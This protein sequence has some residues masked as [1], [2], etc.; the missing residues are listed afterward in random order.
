MS[1]VPLLD[2]RAQYAAIR[3]KCREAIDRVV[4]SQGLILGP[5]VE[6]F[7]REIAA[8]CGCEHAIG[9]SSG[10]DALLMAL[11]ALDVGRDDEV[12]IPAYT[13]FATA[14]SIAR[15][16]AKPVFVDVD[17][18]SLNIAVAK[19]EERIT[20]KTR[21][22]I[23]VH[24]YGQ[25]VDMDVLLAVTKRYGVPVIE[26]AA[27]AI[28]ATTEKGPAGSLGDIGCFSFYPT[29]NLG[30]FGDAGLVTARNGGLAD[31]LRLLRVHGMPERYLHTL[32]GGNFRLDAIQAAVLRVKL[33]YLDEWIEARQRNAAAYNRLFAEAGIAFSADEAAARLAEPCDAK[34]G[35]LSDARK[36]V[37]PAES[38]SPD[39]YGLRG[40]SAPFPGHRHVYNCYVIRTGQRD[41]VIAELKKAGIDHMIYYPFT[42]PQ[43]ECFKDLGHRKGDFPVS[44]C[45]ALT[46][47]ALPMFAELTEAQIAEVVQAVA[48]GLKT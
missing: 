32:L 4:E 3:G 33:A 39:R 2:L 36:I 41:A 23:P 29:K 7:E 24:L 48:R 42:L 31:R 30:A 15:L 10:T 1:P 27:Q 18:V 14:G 13:F 16:G 5:E 17:P 11:M 25:C 26:D 34:A 44:E 12:I 37:L 43:Q 8:Y 47:L 19:I 22:V 21:A 40:T 35:C 46:S 38:P 6:A 28:G 20:P 45:A 9:C